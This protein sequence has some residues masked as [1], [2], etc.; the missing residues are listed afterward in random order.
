MAN[1]SGHLISVVIPSFS[2]AER[3]FTS[4][5]GTILCGKRN[6]V[7]HD[8]PW[9][10]GCTLK[11]ALVHSRLDPAGK[12]IRA[13]IDA[14]LA[15]PEARS[16]FPLEQ[17]ELAFFEAPERLIF[18]DHI[19]RKLSADL[20]I[21][22][23]R[24]AST[25]PARVLT[26]HVTGNIGT[27]ELG[28]VAG[29]VAVAS[30]AWMHAVLC[31]LS[32]HAPPGYRVSYEVTHHGP[33]EIDTPS[34]FVEIGS[35]EEEWTDARA[36]HAVAQSLLE[37]EPAETLNLTGIG[38]THYA[39]RETGIA[40]Q[41]RAAFGH[42]VH[43]RYASSLDQE[44]LAALVTKSAAGAVY[45]DRKA[46]SSG[47]LDRIDALAAGLGIFRL[48]ETEILQL[49]HISLS[50]WNEIRSIAQQ[51]CPGS[52]VS[53]SGALREGVPCQIALPADLLAE[54]LR[55]D[56]AGF[57]AALDHLPIAFFSWGGIPVLPEVVTTGE[58]PPDILNDL[59]SL[60]V[61]T[62]CS[63]ETTAIEGDR[64]IIRRTGF[65]PEKARNLG[66]PPGP[67][68]GELMKGNVVAV[69]GREIT[70]DMVRISRVTCIRIP[71]LEK[72]I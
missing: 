45:V 37:A 13:V 42:I 18:Q 57:R 61:T 32:R 38:G 55:V 12:N 20:I 2:N 10:E 4:S 54:T 59:I 46:V 11:I 35:T 53:I 43:S 17:H 6:R 28:G 1:A 70:P 51:I 62:I 16:P 30:P 67:L 58:N 41:S 49:R 29:S 23:S 60:C 31:G 48:S 3:I 72:L 64:L 47:E 25:R 21:F 14:I 69:N 65:D 33:T 34:F 66:I 8:L 36:G 19:D 26:V 63:G 71:G 7:Y 56:P 27:A 52:S 50:L 68:Y 24:H 5:I 40:L 22:L 39:R 9:K 15:D 44:M